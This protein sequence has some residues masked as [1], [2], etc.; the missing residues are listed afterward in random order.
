MERHELYYDIW[1]DA[2]RITEVQD[3]DDDVCVVAAM[4]LASGALG[5]DEEVIAAAI[6]VDEYRLRPFADT[7]RKE[8]VWRNGK[9]CDSGWFGEDGGMALLVDVCAV[10]GL[11]TRRR[12]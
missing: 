3:P 6:E 4:L 12:R 10:Q 1:R 5:P 2:Q 8:G 9:V 11:L 7:A